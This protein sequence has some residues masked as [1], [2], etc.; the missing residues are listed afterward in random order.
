MSTS[1]IQQLGLSEASARVLQ[2]QLESSLSGTSFKIGLGAAY[3]LAAIFWTV[4]AGVIAWLA[5]I[6]S[7]EAN[8]MLLAAGLVTL[9]FI[10]IPWFTLR[11]MRHLDRARRGV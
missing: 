2:A 1:Q 3:V 4:S 9:P 8:P 7:R 5:T 6:A 11:H 10:L